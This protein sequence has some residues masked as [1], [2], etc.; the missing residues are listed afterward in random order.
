MFQSKKL[1]L[2]TPFNSYNVTQFD[3]YLLTGWLSTSRAQYHHYQTLFSM[4]SSK[5]NRN[6]YSCVYVHTVSW[7]L[8][9]KESKGQFEQSKRPVPPTQALCF[10]MM[11]GVAGGWA[12]FH[13]NLCHLWSLNRY[14][15]ILTPLFSFPGVTGSVAWSREWLLPL[16][17]LLPPPPWLRWPGLLSVNS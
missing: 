16:L 17:L 9:V 5:C 4:T 1:E 11:S 10:T 3:H 6:T 7:P 2:F 14:W 13:L 12:C 8:K 15:L